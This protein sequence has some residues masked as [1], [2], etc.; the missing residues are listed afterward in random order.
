MFLARLSENAE[1][2]RSQSR[3]FVQIWQTNNRAGSTYVPKPC[4][5]VVTDFRPL[6]LYRMFN[7]PNAKWEHLAQEWQEIVTLPVCW[8]SPL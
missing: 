1:T 3:I 4:A 5:G 6:K 2:V 8:S 7:N